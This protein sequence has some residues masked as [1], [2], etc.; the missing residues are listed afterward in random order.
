MSLN[1]KKAT[2]GHMDTP[3]PLQILRSTASNVHKSVVMT[4]TSCPLALPDKDKTG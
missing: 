2:S 3:R 1:L 4:V